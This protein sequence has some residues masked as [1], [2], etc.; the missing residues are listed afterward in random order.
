MKEIIADVGEL[1]SRVALLEDGVLQRYEIAR[2]A[3]EPVTGNIYIGKVENV[4][5][6]MQ[7]AF[8]NIGLERNAF[9]YAG[10]IFLPEGGDGE[11]R[12]RLLF[13]N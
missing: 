5:S 7:A 9:L 3:A 8:V 13:Q 4:L 11:R 12:E 10:D 2:K 6:G 1:Q